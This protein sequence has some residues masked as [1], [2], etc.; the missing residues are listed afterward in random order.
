MFVLC[1]L[2]KDRRMSRDKLGC[3]AHSLQAARCGR[4]G[5]IVGEFRENFHLKFRIIYSL[6]GTPL[7][8]LVH[9]NF[10]VRKLRKYLSYF[11]SNVILREFI[12]YTYQGSVLCKYFKYLK[13]GMATRLS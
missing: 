10:A 9:T 6:R 5:G 4:A 11:N 13:F 12:L 2:A 8:S 3:A 7:F 1:K